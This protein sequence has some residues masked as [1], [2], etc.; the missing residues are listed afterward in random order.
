MEV[1]TLAG[2]ALLSATF[3]LLL[4]KLSS[5]VSE[6]L[7]LPEKVRAEMQ[8]WKILLPKFG[9]LLEDAE[10]KQGRARFVKLWLADLEDLFYDMEDILEEVE[11]DA[12]RFERSA[13]VQAS[14]SKRRKLTCPTEMV[15]R[16]EEITARLRRF[17]AN[18][19]SL[20]L[21]SSAIRT[22]DRFHRVT[23]ERLP[24]TPLLEQHVYGRENDKEAIL[25]ILL[26]DEGNHEPYSVIPIV[27][28]GGIGKTT[29]ARLIYNDDKLRGRFGLKAWVCVSE[30]FDV[31]RITRAILE[32]VTR[33][34]CD[35]KELTL[36]QESL[37]DKLSGQKFLL[38]L[39]DIWNENY[40]LWE[41]LQ[42]PFLRGAPGSKIIITTRIENIGKMIRGNDRVHHLS[43]LE[44]GACL[45]LFARHALGA[46]NFDGYPDLKRVGE[47]IVEKCKR[48]PLAIQSLS[49]LLRGKADLAEWENILN[50]EIWDL[51]D[52]NGSILPALKLSYNHLPSHLKRCF[53]YCSMFPKDYEFDEGELVLLWMAEGFLQQQPQTIKKMKD[54]GHQSFR[55][56]LS[57][58][59]FQRSNRN[60]S[61]FVMHDLMV[62]LALQVAGDICYTLESDGDISDMRFQRVR[63]LSLFPSHYEVSKRFEFLKEKK[64]LRTVW[65]L[66]DFRDSYYLSNTLLQDLMKDLKCLRVL[67]LQNCKI[68]KLS[69]QI[70]DLKH[71]RFINLSNTEIESLPESVSYLLYLQT[72]LLRDCYRLSNLPTSIGNLLDLQHLDLVETKS[73]KE[74]PSEINKLTRLVTLS[75]FIVGDARGPRVKDLKNLSG[76]QGQLSILDLQNVVAANEAKEVNL[77]QIEGLDD[78]SLEWSSNFLNNRNE[79][80]ELQVLSWLEPYHGLKRLTINC[81]GGLEFPPWIGNPSFSN[82]EFLKLNNCQKS[83]SLPSLQRLP[84][85]KELIIKGIHAIETMM[86]DKDNSSSASAFPSLES[87]K[88]Q[89]CPILKGKFPKCIPVLKKLEIAECPELIY[90]PISLPSL[91]E[92]C[93]EGCSEAILRSIV[94]LNSLKTLRISRICKLIWL[95]KSF[96]E[97]LIA[98]KNMM[99]TSCDELTC[100]WEEGANMVNLPCLKRMEIGWCPLL[101][102]LTRKEQGF[103]PNSV[104]TLDIHDCGA[105]ESLPSEMMM[106]RLKE[107]YISGCPAL[108]MFLRGKLP[109]MLKILRIKECEKLESLPEGILMNNG[110]ACQVSHLEELSIERCPCLKFFPTGHL[111]NS[112][113]R[114][115]VRDCKQLEFIPQRMLQYYRELEEIQLYGNCP[116]YRVPDYGRRYTHNCSGIDKLDGLDG[117]ESLCPFIPNLKRL[118]IRSF[119][120]LKCLP[121]KLQHLNSL[122]DLCISNCPGIESIPDGGLPSNLLA[123]EIFNCPGIESI[124]DFGFPPNLRD[125]RIFDCENLKSLPDKL[126]DL[127]SLDELRIVNCPR[128]ESI[129]DSGLPPNLTSLGIFNCPRIKSISESGLPP[130]LT[131]LQIHNCPGIE[132]ISDS[133]FPPN[134]EF[135]QIHHC[136]GI[137]SIPYC[138]SAPNLGKLIIGCENL[139]KP[140]QEWGLSSITSLLTFQI[141]WICPPD[142][143]L[144]TS[145]TSLEVCNVENMKSISRGL[146]QN[147]NSLQRLTIMEWPKLQTL[148][149]E[150]LPASLQVLTF[151]NCNNFQSLPNKVLPPSLQRLSI[152]FCANFQSLP[153]EGLPPSLKRLE[154]TYCPLLQRR[155]MEEKGQDWPLIAHIPNVDVLPREQEGNLQYF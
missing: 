84:R 27:G 79:R 83:T 15:S 131:S 138:G 19:S 48:L 135:L 122:D 96:V 50:S 136:P 88:L 89:D 118:T 143:V 124:P 29:L 13:E 70:G 46:E 28:M 7:N 42:R 32:H 98:L 111:P 21:V 87:L 52:G 78:L 57:R 145:L 152:R 35:L 1:A 103:L 45:S 3:D 97:S 142:N 102:S 109:I 115:Y 54:L 64:N 121:N 18:I 133:G 4:S 119:K 81:F 126:L 6:W 73:L 127:N 67:S 11:I 56:L 86:L 51:P 2:G 108:R 16:V 80:S 134:L 66:R 92:L 74:F 154:I 17:E 140:M 14:T 68:T 49:G 105:L 110:D 36:L 60:E 53:A 91:E 65:R 76:L 41:N 30:D 62:D 82:L 99:I 10:E 137:E 129:S 132:S 149:K 8:N 43:L 72:L 148:P 9:V 146:L 37:Q 114:L 94:D 33:E 75:K 25:Q 128:I 61:L 123:L 151:W 106:E 26:S 47:K 155:C 20:H 100:L 85:L 117:L 90:S 58:A 144:P 112:F 55:E 40:I 141:R 113:K 101:A 44:D 150:A 71:L 22:G 120:N 69:D 130:N 139:K 31:Y 34:N 59:F 95:P 107:L 153:K 93:V 5:S 63:H 24:T 39:D 23:A 12:K 77:F 147:L 38:V 104:Q 125:L 116:E